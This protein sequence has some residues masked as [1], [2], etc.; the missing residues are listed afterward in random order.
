MAEVEWYHSKC[1]V[2]MVEDTVEMTYL[3]VES[4]TE[5]L[6]C[7]KCGAVYLREETVV[8]KVTKAEEMIEYK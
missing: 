1:Q 5:G 2:P 7:P 3:G 4:P 8:E 6:K